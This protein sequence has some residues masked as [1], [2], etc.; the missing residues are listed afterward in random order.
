MPHG[1]VVDLSDYM[2]ID[3]VQAMS[4]PTVDSILYGGK[5]AVVSD[6]SGLNAMLSND[7]AVVN[8]TLNDDVVA[9][10]IITVPEGKKLNLNLGGN[11]LS[12]SGLA[13]NVDGGEAVISNGSVA[14]SANDAIT[15]R[16]GGTVT[17]DGADITSTSR[18]AI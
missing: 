10:T 8:V 4:I 17:I 14:S 2:L 9:N 5:T 15:V 18:N 7:N 6:L 16:N 3:D 11:T 13:L 1:L 12:A